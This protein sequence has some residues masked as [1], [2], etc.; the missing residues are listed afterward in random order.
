MSETQSSS[1]TPPLPPLIKLEPG[2]IQTS[3][4]ASST[5]YETAIAVHNIETNMDI[6]HSDVKPNIQMQHIKP[7][8]LETNITLWQFLLELLMDKARQH[9]ITWTGNEGEF[10]LLN[11]EEVARLWGLRKNK[12]NMNY[13]KLSRALRY[14]YDK[15]IIKKVMGQK[16]VYKFV[17][18][19]EIVKTENKIPFRV[20][21]ES[22]DV[23]TTSQRPRSYP[24]VSRSNSPSV[25]TSDEKEKGRSTPAKSPQRLLHTP[26]PVPRSPRPSS[27]ELRMLA[28]QV[29]REKFQWTSALRRE[30]DDMLSRPPVTV[31][32]Q[33]V[34]IT[35]ARINGETKLVST[36]GRP[37]PS[38]TLTTACSD[39]RTGHL[40]AKS[41]L[42][43]GSSLGNRPKPLQ[44]SVPLTIKGSE[45]SSSSSGKA[46]SSPSYLHASTTG[47]LSAVSAYGPHTPGLPGTPIMVASPL[48]GQN[49]TPLVP[50]HFWSTLSP[51]TLSPSLN[52]NTSFQFPTLVSN[53]L[54]SPL[55]VNGVPVTPT[56]LLSPASTKPIFVS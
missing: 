49:G 47:A 1:R 26:S 11:A 30:G 7:K 27:T 54:S 4:I 56:V 17:S 32:V 33:D 45:S 53:G 28:K 6:S 8:G 16:F 14:Y 21:M 40:R 3:S 18:F 43:T 12:T 10:K 13:D 31:N 2:T 50:I 38:S 19:P 36:G 9:L 52:G 34:Y 5:S 22:M 41:P 35:E 48:L 24:S 23:P 15:N 46:G 20:K 42:V 39:G 44:L 51:L 37:I 29:D 25:S 55:T